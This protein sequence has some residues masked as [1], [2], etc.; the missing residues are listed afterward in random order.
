[1][2]TEKVRS[3]AC[4]NRWFKRV[5]VSDRQIRRAKLRRD[6]EALRR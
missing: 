1:M 5:G 2:G 6:D 3:A 4:W